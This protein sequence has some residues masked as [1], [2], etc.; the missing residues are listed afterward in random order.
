MPA[1]L[2]SPFNR[3]PPRPRV[4]GT[5]AP[6]TVACC[7]PCCRAQAVHHIGERERGV[8]VHFAA[9]ASRALCRWFCAAVADPW[10]QAGSLYFDLVASALFCRGLSW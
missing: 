8:I 10:V 5:L 9:L 7:P 6:L 1:P 2:P 3:R 4:L